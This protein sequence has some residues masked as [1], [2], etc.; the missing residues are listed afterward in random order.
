MDVQSKISSNCYL[1]SEIEAYLKDAGFQE[2]MYEIKAYEDRNFIRVFMSE[3]GI[4][5][6]LKDIIKTNWRNKLEITKYK[7][8]NYNFSA[9]FV[10]K[11]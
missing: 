6:I 8:D 4:D 3:K 1:K 9:I 10:F 2:Y 7:K 11:K 5:F